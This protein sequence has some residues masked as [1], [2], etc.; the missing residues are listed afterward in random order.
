MKNS[1]ILLI[2][3]IGS[4][5]FGQTDSL[6]KDIIYKKLINKQIEQAEF[7]TIYTRWNQTI[8]KINK[9]PDL[10]LD[11]TGQVHY[12]FLKE[13]TGINKEKLFTL[14]LEY[15]STNYALFPSYLYSNLDEGKIILRNTINLI[16]GDNCTYTSVILIK[17]EKM[18]IEFINIGYQ[19]FKDGYYTDGAWVPERTINYG[20]NQ[21]YPIIL[22]KPSEWNSNIILFKITNEFFNSEIENFSHY[23]I[24]YDNSNAF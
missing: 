11:Q 2:L 6:E 1:L 8:K 13:F 4:N 17:N 16:T 23:V 3:F 22:K 24:N 5:L 14:T 10:P 21:V 15:F 9:Y 19:S 12:S 18:L 20:I 7:A